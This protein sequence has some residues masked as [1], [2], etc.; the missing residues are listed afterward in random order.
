K[1][2]AEK[3]A[4]EAQKAAA[5]RA[6]RDHLAKIAAAEAAKAKAEADRIAAEKAE[7]Q[8]IELEKAEAFQRQQ[9]AD[10]ERLRLEALEPDIPKIRRLGGAVN[11]LLAVSWPPLQSDD[12]KATYE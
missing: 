8:R 2:E 12:A 6:E 10:K 7:A 5:E 9:A 4:F 11:N 1:L 3:K